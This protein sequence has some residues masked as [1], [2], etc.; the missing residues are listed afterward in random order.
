MVVLSEKTSRFH[1][2]HVV[3]KPTQAD[4][5]EIVECWRWALLQVLTAARG[6]FCC[7]DR[8][9]DGRSEPRRSLGGRSRS[10]GVA[11]PVVS[12]IRKAYATHAQAVGGGRMVNLASRR[13]FSAMAARVNSSCAP[14]GPCRPPSS[15]FRS[16]A[17]PV[18][19]AVSAHPTGSHR[20]TVTLCTP[21]LRRAHLARD[22]RFD[23]DQS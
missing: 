3:L 1:P 5:F 9:V 14:R 23:L 13:K 21:S 19:T 15:G 7:R 11:A 18:S 16:P 12:F 2:R 20:Q 22:Q 8:R 6:R 17:K 4:A 10:R